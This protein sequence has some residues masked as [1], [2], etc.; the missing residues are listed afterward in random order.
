[1]TVA[2]DVP[3]PIRAS[4]RSVHP[5]SPSHP[6]V[7]GPGPW[8]GAGGRRSCA[9]GKGQPTRESLGHRRSCRCQAQ[10]RGPGPLE[11]RWGGVCG[12][13]IGQLLVLNCPW[14]TGVLAP[15]PQYWEPP[16]DGGADTHPR[17][18]SQKLEAPKPQA[19][20]A[21]GRRGQAPAPGPSLELPQ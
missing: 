8:E 13:R 10:S 5:S 21:A 7:L 1:M 9:S 11:V 18:G 4:S 2:A 20:L 16:R 15:A 6:K 19:G 12:A 17:G 3:L 14:K